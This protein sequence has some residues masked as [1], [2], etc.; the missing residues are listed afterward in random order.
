M[1]EQP[2]LTI[3]MTTMKEKMRNDQIDLI[4]KNGDYGDIFVNKLKERDDKY[5]QMIYDGALT[6]NIET[7]KE[8]VRFNKNRFQN[9]KNKKIS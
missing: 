9:Y 5:I 4:R 1:K 3:N 2:K 8:F 7:N 6:G